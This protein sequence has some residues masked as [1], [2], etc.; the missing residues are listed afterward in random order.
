M[1]KKNKIIDE[2]IRIEGGYINDPSDSGGETK[3]GITEATARACGI[4]K[5]IKDL[6]RTDAFEIYESMYW[7]AV[8]ADSLEKINALIAEIVVDYAV[9]SGA[10]IAAKTLQRLLNALNNCQKLYN[11]IAVDG[12]IGSKTIGA[13]SV[14]V[15]NRKPRN[16]VISYQSLR[17]AFLI[18]LVERREKDEKFIYGWLKRVFGDV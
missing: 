1:S 5:P 13:L 16:F 11:D 6:T 14:Y 8:N 9:H 17:L 3:Y 15:A 7:H 18:E 10:V 2:I 12:I 4:E